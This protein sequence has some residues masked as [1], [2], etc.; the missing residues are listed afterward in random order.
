MLHPKLDKLEQ[1]F[2]KSFLT[3]IFDPLLEKKQISCWVKRDDQ[4]DPIISGNKWR[5][6]K[7]SLDHA[8]KMNYHTVVSMGGAYSNH[9]HALA[10]TC[11]QLN[12]KSIGFIRGE[13]PKSMNSTLKDLQHWGMKLHFISRAQYRELRNCNHQ[14]KI[15]ALKSGEFWLAEGGASELALKGVAELTTEYHQQFNTVCVPCGTGTTL[16]GIIAASD[17][18]TQIYGFSA[19]KGAGFLRD[20]VKKLLS[21]QRVNNTHWDIQLAY[22]FGGFAKHDQNLLT[23]MNHFEDQHNI[24]LEPIYTAKMFYGL[25]DL[26]QQDHFKPGIKIMALHTGGLQGNRN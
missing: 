12:I 18:T 2:Q 9:L 14:D 24:K 19:L 4:I 11:K 15:L 1:S 8:L 20:D 3:Q 23:F 13:Q 10:Y 7:Y 26:I 25:F 16:A 17:P 6:L 21:K 22:H 5:K